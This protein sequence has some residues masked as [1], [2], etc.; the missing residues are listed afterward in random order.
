MQIDI[1][2]D[3]RTNTLGSLWM[4]GAMAAF[5][6]EDSLIKLAAQTLEVGQILVLFGLGGALIFAGIARMQRDRLCTAD[7]ISPAMRLRVGFEITG[8][9]FFALAITLTPL[10]SATVILQATPLVVVAGAAMV[11]GEKVGPRR[12]I[13]IGIGLLGVLV[14]VQPGSDSFSLL[15]LLAVIAMFGFAGRDLASRAAPRALSASVLGFYGF[16]SVV[17][18]GV[19]YTLWAG[20]TFEPLSGGAALYLMGATFAGVLAYTSLMKAMRMGQVS[21][22]TPFR[23]TRLLFGIG[24]GVMLFGEQLSWS[25][26][27]GCALIVV[28][29]LFTLWRGQ[30]ASAPV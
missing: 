12:W 13:A 10:S 4:V 3:T 26:L 16:L 28:S 24:F 30:K 29:G 22:V 9:L 11:F 7:A 1:A 5:A 8:R 14:I 18:A 20:Q 19:F 27:A 23:Y 17:M 25:V 2:T 15:S 21:A 6:L